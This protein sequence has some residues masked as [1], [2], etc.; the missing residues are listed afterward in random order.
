MTSIEVYNGN[1]STI[2]YKELDLV[3]DVNKWLKEKHPTAT[4]AYSRFP[5]NCEYKHTPKENGFFKATPI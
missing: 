3:S 4:K 5:D 2:H 1:N